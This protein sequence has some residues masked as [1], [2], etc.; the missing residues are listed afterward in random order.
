MATATTLTP[1]EVI[2][3]V[4]AAR[5]AEH[6]AAVEQ[7]E[8]ALEWARLHPCPANE[9]PAHWGEADLH[10]EG[11]VPL[12]G[13]G[14]PWV[15][16]FAPVHLAAALGITHDAAR[17]LI[18]DALELAYR[19]PRLWKRVLAG[20][21]PVWR[22]RLIARET[23][24]LSEKAV[25]F[26]DRLIAATPRRIGQVQAA[27]LVQ[28]ARLYFDPDRAVADE[29]EALA[30]RGVWLRHGSA[31]ATT[32]V[33]MTLDTPDALLLDQTVTR[34]ASDLRELG[35]TDELEVRRARAVGILA[36]PQFALDLLSGRDA[37]PRHR[38]V[39]TNLYVHLTAA[40][41]AADV[42]D[43]TGAASIEKLGAATTQLLT[44]WLTRFAAAGTK[45]TLRP[46]L[47]LGSQAAADQHDPPDA[48]RETVLL[49]DAHCVF[50]GCH[51]DSRICDLDHITE[52]LPMEDG[53]PPGQTWPGNLAPLCRR[54]HRVK[55]HTAW[56]YKRLDDGRYV[57]TAPTG[58]Q[59]AVT[60][61]SRLP[62]ID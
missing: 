55:T 50:P 59:H 22:A 4:R 9:T 28:E 24:N 2:D 56:R 46:V 27:R 57:W 15:A 7:L 53:G 51:R 37:A 48:M 39:G 21:V 35:D 49:R 10:D 47:D 62:R 13:P 34:L 8:L 33:T 5:K 1:T 23:T 16:E 54:H 61:V 43:G 19:L 12:A 32:D 30:K 40:D 11:L 18:A 6:Q 25:S 41:L 3:R 17:Q 52:Y 31:P 20:E 36:D 44:G 58:H 45:I 38:G 29:E 26:A 42:A 14:A 60:P